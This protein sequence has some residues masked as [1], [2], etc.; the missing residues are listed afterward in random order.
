MPYTAILY[1]NEEQ[2]RTK[3]KKLGG[4]REKNVKCAFILFIFNT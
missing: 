1:Y 2:G 4:G 3:E